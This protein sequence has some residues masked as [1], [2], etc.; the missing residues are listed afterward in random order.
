MVK[1]FKFGAIISAGFG[2]II[3]S[4]LGVYLGNKWF[5]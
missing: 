4:G 1:L 3:G 5:R 2:V